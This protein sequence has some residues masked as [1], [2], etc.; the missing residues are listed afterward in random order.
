MQFSS[1]SLP[2]FPFFPCT[3]SKIFPNSQPRRIIYTPEYYSYHSLFCYYPLL[4]ELYTNIAVRAPGQQ[5]LCGFCRDGARTAKTRAAQGANDSGW[6][7]IYKVQHSPG[8]YILQNT[9]MWGGGWPAG[10]KILK[11]EGKE[12]RKT[13]ERRNPPKMSSPCG[14]IIDFSGRG[15]GGNNMIPLEKGENCIN[16]K[17]KCLKKRSFLS[18]KQCW[19]CGGALRKIRNIYHE[20]RSH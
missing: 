17:V 3:F 13:K 7:C 14:C 19:R 4:T 2:L 11:K 20:E 16:N 5:I 10:K 9:M 1:F 6:I 12:K 8:V 15:G 18:Y